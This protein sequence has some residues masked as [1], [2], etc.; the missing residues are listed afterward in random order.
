MRRNRRNVI[1]INNI[2]NCDKPR[3]LI[4][5]V[6]QNNTNDEVSEEDNFK[7]LSLFKKINKV[8][9]KKRKG[10]TACTASVLS[11]ITALGFKFISLVFFAVFIVL[12]YMA[13][14]YIPLSGNVFVGIIEAIVFIILIAATLLCF[15]LFWQAGNEINNAKDSNY[16]ANVFSGMM[17]FFAIIIAIIAICYDDS[18]EIVEILKNIETILQG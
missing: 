3:K 9:I 12:V 6:H 13:V 16:I 10:G 17:G 11:I 7:N 4:V 2:I 8:L 14:K 18:S 5:K 15:R 1:I